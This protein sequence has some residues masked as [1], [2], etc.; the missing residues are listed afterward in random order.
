[1]T[2][3]GIRYWCSRDDSRGATGHFHSH[4]FGKPRLKYGCTYCR[5]PLVT[6]TGYWVVFTRDPVTWAYTREVPGCRFPG[7]KAA[8]RCVQEKHDT[9][10]YD[11]GF[12]TRWVPDNT[13][14]ETACTPQQQQPST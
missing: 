9:E 5:G 7:Q 6:E 3:S 1:M 13:G 11:P 12:V 4:G 10:G 8:E 14:T 2:K